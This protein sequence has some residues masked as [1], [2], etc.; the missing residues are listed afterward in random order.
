MV[1]GGMTL[2]VASASPNCSDVTEEDR[3]IKFDAL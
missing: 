1:H 3:Q 2:H